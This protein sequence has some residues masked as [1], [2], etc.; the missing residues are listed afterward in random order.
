MVLK[1]CLAWVPMVFI[2]IANG[3]VREKLYGPYM[4]ELAAHQIS[5]ISAVV[6]FALY[7]FLLNRFLPFSSADQA[8]LVGLLWL[9]L[10][11][12]FEFGMVIGLQGESMDTALA[13]YN[14]LAGRVWVLVLTVVAMLPWTIFQISNSGR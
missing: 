7:T 9:G 4:S 10:T 3:A 14:L 13:E 2:A 8:I 6:L 11:L 12:V 1:Y 5:S